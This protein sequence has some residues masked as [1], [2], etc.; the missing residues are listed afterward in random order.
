V[1]RSLHSRTAGLGGAPPSELGRALDALRISLRRATDFMDP[2]VQFHDEVAMAPT[3]MEEGEHA[4]NPNL[5]EV[6]AALSG[7]VFGQRAEPQNVLLMHVG[8]H[9]FWHGTCRLGPRMAVFFYFE[10]L[11]MGLAGIVKSLTDTKVDLVRFSLIQAPGATG[12]SRDRGQ[13]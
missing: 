10:E 4:D 6:L 3:L 8:E 2:W 9:G 7:K 5:L 12:P 11:D 1:K 13:A